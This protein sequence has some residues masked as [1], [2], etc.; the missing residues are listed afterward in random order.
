MFFG[1]ESRR[2]FLTF[3]FSVIN[4]SSIYYFFKIFR[5]YFNGPSKLGISP[6]NLYTTKSITFTE[7]K[8]TLGKIK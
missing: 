4:V 6:I 1:F 2:F 5:D 8:K 3:L 7:G